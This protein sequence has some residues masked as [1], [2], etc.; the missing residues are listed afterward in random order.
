R[1]GE[2]NEDL[3]MVRLAGHGR[4]AVQESG[5]GSLGFQRPRED[6][7]EGRRPDDSPIHRFTSS[8]RTRSG[9]G[10]WPRWIRTTIPRSKVWCPA[11][12]RG[13]SGYTGLELSESF[14]LAGGADLPATCP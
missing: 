5:L 13:A 12:G 6:R 1:V 3:V 14:G 8:G 7:Q 2:G 11:V 4:T 10:N 9:D